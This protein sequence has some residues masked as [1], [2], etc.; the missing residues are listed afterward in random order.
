MQLRTKVKNYFLSGKQALC[1]TNVNKVVFE[2]IGG[3]IINQY[4]SFLN[5]NRF[6]L[7]RLSVT[8]TLQIPHQLRET[9]YKPKIHIFSSKK[10]NETNS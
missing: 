9:I 2:K 10:G 3:P 8:F 6:E 4:N 5:K 7:I 1:K